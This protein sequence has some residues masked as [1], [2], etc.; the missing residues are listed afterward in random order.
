MHKATALANAYYWNKG[1]ILSHQ[2][3]RFK[4]WLPDEEALKIIDQE[5]LDMLHYLENFPVDGLD[6]E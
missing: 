3:K 6:E 2:N 1:Y 4:I 5:E